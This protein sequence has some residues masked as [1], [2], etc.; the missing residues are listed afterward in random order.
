MRQKICPS[1]DKKLCT[2]ILFQE[3]Y[4]SSKYSLL[5][6][7]LHRIDRTQKYNLRENKAAPDS[8]TKLTAFWKKK[9]LNKNQLA[10]TLHLEKVTSG[11]ND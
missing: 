10:S 9:N 3:N 6:K 4:N 5:L 8:E 2:I 7:H 11:K 1:H